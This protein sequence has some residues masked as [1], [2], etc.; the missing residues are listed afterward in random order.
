MKRMNSYCLFLLAILSP[1]SWSDLLIKEGRLED[2]IEA[3]L[4]SVSDPF[5]ERFFSVGQMGRQPLTGWLC[6]AT[7]VAGSET[8]SSEKPA[9][10]LTAGHCA[11]GL[12]GENEVVFDRPMD[13]GW[14]FI[15][16][17][18]YDNKEK[19]LKFP[20]DKILY[21]TLKGVDV[22]VLQ[23]KDTYGAMHAKGFKPMV[24]KAASD[25]KFDMEIVHVPIAGPMKE[26]FMR[27]SNCQALDRAAVFEAG[28]RDEHDRI[29]PWFW[30]NTVPN[31]CV[32]VYGG[33]SGAP[34]FVTGTQAVSAV[35]STSLKSPGT[36]CDEPNM[37]CE[38]IEGQPVG[39]PQTVYLG[40]VDPLVKAFKP[41]GTFDA[42]TLD[43]GTGVV[44]QD[45]RGNTP[46]YS[47]ERGV[48]RLPARWD[49]RIDEA[50][51]H[52]RYK[53]GFADYVHCEDPRGY[54]E[55]IPV[56][57]QPL[58][59]LPTPDVPALYAVCVIGKRPGS[60]EWQ[61]FSQATVKLRR[62]TPPIDSQ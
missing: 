32:G 42:S 49:L 60:T 54:S 48:K 53:I 12:T 37:P 13:E 7:L 18:F 28:Y 50:H 58:L 17:Y 29:H 25:L 59:N 3:E 35:L 47:L 21:S 15:P 9:L 8:P 27:Y 16:S 19:H 46:S 34:V 62:I 20:I 39:K 43:P 61:A 5:S 41:D 30:P 40:A 36:A 11:A 31:Q 22:A 52:V 45:T 10:L 4:L 38:I 23:L 57:S 14:Y 6:T 26:R 51:E 1:G 55:P 44:L 24:V 33:S 2:K 56:V